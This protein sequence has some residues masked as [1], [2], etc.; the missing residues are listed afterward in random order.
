MIGLGVTSLPTNLKLTRPIFFFCHEIEF[1]LTEDYSV[2]LS[3]VIFGRDLCSLPIIGKIK[4]ARKFY[5]CSYIYACVIHYMVLTY[6]FL[7]AVELKP[8]KKRRLKYN[9]MLRKAILFKNNKF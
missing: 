9:T 2:V 1:S 8:I 4:E 3:C 5:S 6:K 7:M